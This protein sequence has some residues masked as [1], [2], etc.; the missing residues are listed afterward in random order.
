MIPG[1][2]QRAL[3][4]NPAAWKHFENLA[5]SYR[6]TYVG[7]IDSARREE[8]RMRRLAEA[9]GLLAAGRKLGMK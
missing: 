7:W 4:K 1:Y 9:I 2:I 8:T 5:P 3:R 6:R